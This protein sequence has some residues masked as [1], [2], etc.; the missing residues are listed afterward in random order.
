MSPP[1]DGAEAVRQI[2][3][4][5]DADWPDPEP[6]FE[7]TEAERPYPLEALPPVIAN[8]VEE[9][10]GYGQQPLP[11]IASSALSSV[12]LGRAGAS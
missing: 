7:P 4:G 9:Y 10:W 5:E 6:L 3:V 11:L 12:S 1:P 8:A 2:V